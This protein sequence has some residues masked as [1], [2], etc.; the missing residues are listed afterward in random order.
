MSA[1]A[2]ATLWMAIGAETFNY[3]KVAA[4]CLFGGAAAW[5]LSLYFIRFCALGRSAEVW[6]SAAILF[7]STGTIAVTGILFAL[8]YRIF[9]AQWH[10]L[11]LSKLWLIQFVFTTL[12]ALYQFAVIGLRL[13][14]PVGAIALVVTALF[15]A[16]QGT[17]TARQR[18]FSTI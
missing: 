9:Y 1:S 18:V 7:L 14:L 13:Y 12:A 4:L 6:F 5:P 10:A 16:R 17:R 8:D 11:P 3:W 15:L 2:Q